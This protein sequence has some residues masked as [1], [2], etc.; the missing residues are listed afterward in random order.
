MSF[1]WPVS[2]PALVISKVCTFIKGAGMDQERSRLM[3]SLFFFFFRYQK[4]KGKQITGYIL[5]DTKTPVLS[6]DMDNRCS[7]TWRGK[8][9]SRCH[10]IALPSRIWF[11]TKTRTLS[12]SP[13]KKLKTHKIIFILY[14]FK[15]IWW[16]ANTL[17]NFGLNSSCL[18]KES[19]NTSH[20]TD[21]Y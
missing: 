15:Y 17:V 5:F 1:F 13:G 12:G 6:R 2:L 4:G 9:D 19:Q 11:L 10:H 7:Y 14:L 21:E 18:P 8:M 16:C 3:W 20:I